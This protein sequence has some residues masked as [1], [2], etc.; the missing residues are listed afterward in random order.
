MDRLGGSA[1]SA[2]ACYMILT[3]WELPWKQ[4]Q[5]R[6]F[7]FSICIR[8]K[9]IE[10]EFVW[11]SEKHVI[12]PSWWQMCHGVCKSSPILL[13][14]CKPPSLLKWPT[15]SLQIPNV[16]L[17][18]ATCSYRHRTPFILSFHDFFSQAGH[19]ASHI[20]GTHVRVRL[21]CLHLNHVHKLSYSTYCFTW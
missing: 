19:G 13:S 10:T 17:S 14:R 21:C 3:F 12:S 11:E 9:Y 15:S 5:Q 2:S 8:F 16:V 7:R 4:Q 18:S 6:H 1:L 20:P